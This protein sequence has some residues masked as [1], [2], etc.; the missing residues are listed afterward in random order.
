MSQISLTVSNHSQHVK[1][2][3]CTVGDVGNSFSSLTILKISWLQIPSQL[4][5]ASVIV[6]QDDPN[7][8]PK[9]PKNLGELEI[10]EIPDRLGFSLT[11]EN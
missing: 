8:Y 1:T 6:D 2:Q 7:G 9:Y 11:F 10:S 5:T 4:I 3:I